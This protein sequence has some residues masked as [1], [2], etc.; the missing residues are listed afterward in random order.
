MSGTRDDQLLYLLGQVHGEASA[1]RRSLAS[2]DRQLELVRE[3]VT[4]QGKAIGALPCDGHK[5]RLSDLYRALGVVRE[6]H[7]RIKLT[8]TQQRALREERSRWIR[9]TWVGLKFFLLILA[10]AGIGGGIVSTLASIWR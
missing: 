5:R 1:T 4:Q 10:A 6:D 3:A 2:I 9:W 7:D 8:D